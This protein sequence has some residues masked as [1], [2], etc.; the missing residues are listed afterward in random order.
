MGTTESFYKQ[1]LKECNIY[2]EPD[3]TTFVNYIGGSCYQSAKL[4][5]EQFD[6]ISKHISSFLSNKTDTFELTLD[7]IILN[8]QVTNRVSIFGQEAVTHMNDVKALFNT[9]KYISIVCIV[10]L[11]ISATWMIFKRKEIKNYLFKYSLIT[12]GFV[13][14]SAL[15]FILVVF[16][17]TLHKYSAFS[18][19]KFSYMLWT[20]LHYVF[21]PFDQAKFNGS[22]FTDTLTSILTLDFFMGCVKIVVSSIVLTISAWLVACLIIKKK[23]NK[24][25]L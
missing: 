20:Y 8:G 1:Q 14:C 12:I 23:T 13:L 25:M 21:F 6:E 16:I 2:P 15:I 9:V 3:K 19:D 4:T 18:I 7:N 5:S 10:L 17:E 24:K 22:I 11:I